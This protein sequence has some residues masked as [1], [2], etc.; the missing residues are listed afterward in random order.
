MKKLLNLRFD[1][2]FPGASKPEDEISP[3]V[4]DI[5]L[6]AEEMGIAWEVV[7][8]STI[9]K[10]TY[11]GHV[12][13]SYNGSTSTNRTPGPRICGDKQLTRALLIAG[14]IPISQGFAVIQQD[15][16]FDREK[17]FLALRKPLVVKPGFGTHG[18][19]VKM[20]IATLDEMNTWIDHLFSTVERGNELERGTVLIEETV[21]GQEYR[22]IATKEKTLAVMNRQPAS[23]VGDG[24]HTIEQLIAEKNTDPMRNISP[25]LYPH[26]TIDEDMRAVLA[27][28]Q[29]ATNSTP[30]QGQKIILRTVSN[31][32]AGGDAVDMTDEIHPSVADI[33]VRVCRAIPGM[34]LVGIDYMTTDITKDQQ[35]EHH[36][37]IEVNSA[38]EYT[39]HDYPMIGK[40][41]GVAREIL[42]M[43]FPEWTEQNPE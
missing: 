22:I 36:A 9:V 26:I 16:A 1:R 10:F 5:V 38:P 32:M 21:I 3:Q 15:T 43:M 4:Q 24:V 35:F 29:L 13:F 39:M 19:G 17:I 25:T 8:F 20:G 31:I 34:A 37:V 11:N 6:E 12:E 42:K 2:N 27:T 14:G 28:Q 30:A 40:K 41:R 33:A 23:V 7:P 18:S